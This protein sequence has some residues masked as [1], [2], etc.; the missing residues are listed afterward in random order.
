MKTRKKR[1]LKAFPH[2]R[3]IKW[4]TGFEKLESGVKE[5][6]IHDLWLLIYNSTLIM[7]KIII[8]LV[9]E[10][11]SGK[12]TVANHFQ[13]KYGAKL[14][15]FASPI[16]NTLSI[17]FDKLSRKDQRWLYNALKERFGED[18][19][20]R[21]MRKLLNNETGTLLVVNG[22][23]MPCDYDFIKA[24]PNSYVLYVTADQK[25]RWER[26]VSRGEKTDDDISFEKFQELDQQE[27]E[28][29]IPEIG[30]KADKTIVNDQDK[31]FLLKEADKFLAEIGVIEQIED[32]RDEPTFEKKAI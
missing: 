22:L 1:A 24:Y 29:H 32:S 28:V 19:L 14:F 13:Q 23:R 25:L 17:Y 10:A 18:I 11:G 31:D 3:R 2:K 5:K 27:T 12:D 16:K 9:G 6:K 15:R 20:C 30:Q 4:K 8:G 7:K 21:A 26:V